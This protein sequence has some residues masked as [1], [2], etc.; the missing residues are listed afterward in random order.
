MKQDIAEMWVK[1]LRSGDYMQGK[2]KMK[3]EYPDG[4]VRH[5]PLGVL[6]ELAIKAGVNVE[7]SPDATY[8]PK[9]VVFAFDGDF[10]YLPESVMKWSG[11]NSRDGKMIV[12]VWA[13]PHKTTIF[14]TITG[15]SDDLKVDFEHVAT[16]VGRHWER[17]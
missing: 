4:E 12:R 7:E 10:N 8:F 9:H 13:D 11:M 14:N 6:C 17:L 2:C 3:C 15:M 16:Y 1:A 5:C